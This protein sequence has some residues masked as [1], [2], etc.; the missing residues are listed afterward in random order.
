M[1]SIACC[2]ALSVISFIISWVK[3]LWINEATAVNFVNGTLSALTASF[4]HFN[5]FMKLSPLPLVPHT[6]CAEY[7]LQWRM[8]SFSCK[9]QLCSFNLLRFVWSLIAVGCR[10][11]D[12]FFALSFGVE[13]CPIMR[14]GSPS[15]LEKVHTFWLLGVVAQPLA[16]ACEGSV[17][18]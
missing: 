5:W 11:G 17:Y 8:I 14:Q 9:L 15:S 1:S 3:Y 16:S 18:L 6:S 2:L 10:T 4:V 7:A 13:R 12:T